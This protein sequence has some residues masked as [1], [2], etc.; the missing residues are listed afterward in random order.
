MPGS[1]L[2]FIAVN[3]YIVTETN[4]VSEF[5]PAT[6]PR[7][8][9]GILT[10]G[11]VYYLLIPLFVVLVL[12]LLFL[13]VSKDRLKNPIIRSSFYIQAIIW[14]GLIG[15]FLNHLILEYIGRLYFPSVFG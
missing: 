1:I 13:A 14:I 8:Y 5:N 3:Y 7:L 11:F 2:C 4:L 12:T 15:I 6:T 9:L 10:F